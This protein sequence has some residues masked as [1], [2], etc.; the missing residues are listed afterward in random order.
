MQKQIIKNFFLL[1]MF[2]MLPYFAHAAPI[3]VLNFSDIE[4]GPKTGN[5]DNACN[6]SNCGAIVTIWGNYLGSTQGTSKVYVSDQE[7]TAI[8]YWKDADGQ[9]P[10]GPAD[11]YTF[12]K[13][14]E[15]AF[16]IPSGVADGINTIKV[17]VN[18]IDSAT[19]PFTVR[20]GNIYFIKSGGN[21]STGTGAWSSPWATLNGTLNG[22]PR[23]IPGD[24]VYTVGIGASSNVEVGVNADLIGNA[25]NP[26]SVLVYP[27]TT[28]SM[29][30]NNAAFHN[31][32]HGTAPNKTASMYVNFSKFTVN[33]SYQAFS[34]FG[35]SRLVGN[36]VTGAVP[37][38]YSGWVGGACVDMADANMTCSG[39]RLLGNEIHSYGNTAGT[40][41]SHH[42]FYISNRSGKTAVAYE[43]G[44]NNLH[45]NTTYQGI[46]IYDTSS[47][48]PWSGTFKIHD[49]VVKNQSGNAIN[50]NDPSLADYQIYNNLVILDNDYN[51]SGGT[52]IIPGS[53]FRVDTSSANSTFKIYNNTVY[54]YNAVNTFGTGTIDYQNNS[55]IDNRNIAYA[56]GVNGNFTKS[57]NL[58]FSVVNSSLSLPAWASG[59]LN[60]NPLFFN[61]PNYDFSLQS[62]SP[63]KTAGSDATLA[64]APTD[65]FGQPRQAGNVSI[66]AIQYVSAEVDIIAPSAPSGLNVQ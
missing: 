46:H 60:S 33:T 4:S 32:A 53:A 66:G 37:S 1:A 13:M 3:P 52:Y 15:I 26:Y 56:S 64:T 27:N 10:G 48:S 24:I 25:D 63:A 23:L 9:L 28:A 65:F 44:W 6:M 21:D 51:P 38:G 35:Y 11:L 16:A 36:N 29:T 54:G 34:I 61:V 55:M 22:S 14:Q 17:V 49:N 30:A 39:H 62:L 2:F 47:T 58:F 43:I 7:A 31:Y 19:L 8:Y 20:N 5:S 59:S 12:H 45:D 40:D 18:G 41:V 50:M 57:N 42:L